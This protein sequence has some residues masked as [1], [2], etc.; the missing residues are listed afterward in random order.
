MNDLNS[1]PFKE[2][3]F[4]RNEVPELMGVR[5]RDCGRT[6][7][8]HRDLCI[9]CHGRDVEPVGLSRRG[10]LH[11]YTVCRIPVPLLPVPYAVGYIDL[12]EGVRVFARL[13]GGEKGGLR[14]GMEMELTVGPIKTDRDG[15][16]I[17]SY[18]F[19]PTTPS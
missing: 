10:I 2:G 14:T 3:L 4:T 8:P 19:R 6:A 11:T 9:F 5:C 16:E 1:K 13:E 18:K 17:V 12:P 7:F 15:N